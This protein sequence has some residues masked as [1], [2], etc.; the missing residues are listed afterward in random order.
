MMRLRAA[1]SV[2]LALSLLLVGGCGGASGR[3]LLPVGGNRPLPQAVQSGSA[4]D[5]LLQR[6]SDRLVK[7]RH[8][9]EFVG[10]MGRRSDDEQEDI[11]PVLQKK[12][13]D[14][15]YGLMGR[16][17]DIEQALSQ[18]NGKASKWEDGSLH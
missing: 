3:G 4:L 17:A 2:A 7:K 1:C 9:D 14:E 11:F 15:F 10:L 5:R 8:F 13:P 12:S 6:I 18:S 16:S